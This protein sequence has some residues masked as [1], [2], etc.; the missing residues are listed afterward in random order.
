LKR[1]HAK[2]NAA[3]IA[4]LLLTTDAVVTQI[5]EKPAKQAPSDM[6]TYDY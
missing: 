5:K 3:S 6:S 2:Q 1:T 4:V